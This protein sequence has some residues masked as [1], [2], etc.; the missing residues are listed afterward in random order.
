MEDREI[1]AAIAAGDSAGIAAAYDKYAA[2]LYGYCH[3][4][5]RERTDAAG[6]L[7]DTFVIAATRGDLPEASR[8]RPWLYAVA[9]NECLRRLGTTTRTAHR[10]EV[11]PAD[12][13]ADA[14]QLPTEAAERLTSITGGPEQADLPTFVRSILAELKPPEREVI[15]LILRHDLYDSDLATALGVSWSRAHA[16]A[17]RAHGRLEKALRTLLIARTGRETCPELDRLLADWDGQLTE[18]TQELVTRHIEKCETCSARKFGVLRPAAISGLL[19]MATP[20]AELRDQVLMLGSS[21]APDAVPYRQKVVQRAE[22]AGS[23]RFSRAIKPVRMAR[24]RGNPGV[25]IA[26]VAVVLWVAAAVTVTLLVFLG[27]IR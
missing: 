4:M 12:Q 1:V 5:L 20:P 18:Q 24:I 25:A 14:T 27:S 7:Q 10:D 3:W 2:T 15:E 19:P 9:R 21:T 26:T 23:E 16:Q 6:A 17:V 11:D 13:R 8:L 22:S